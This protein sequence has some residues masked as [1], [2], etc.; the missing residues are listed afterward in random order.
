MRV[1]ELEE[2]TAAMT[3]RTYRTNAGR[4]PGSGGCPVYSVIVRC[5][6]FWAG[7]EP[8]GM[9]ETATTSSLF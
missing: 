5:V 1:N 8:V 3:N 9:A 7:K 6:M 2:K 4:S